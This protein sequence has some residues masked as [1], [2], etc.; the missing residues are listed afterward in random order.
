MISNS[1]T[2]HWMGNLSTSR[3]TLL[4]HLDIERRGV[5]IS[6]GSWRYHCPSCR[7]SNGSTL[8]RNTFQ[9]NDRRFERGEKAKQAPSAEF[10]SMKTTD[11]E[12]HVHLSPVSLKSESTVSIVIYAYH[13]PFPW[14]AYVTALYGSSLTPTKVEGYKC[15]L[16]IWLPQENGAGRRRRV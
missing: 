12:N 1:R 7:N 16:T 2:L 6:L 15:P 8:A 11:Q 14:C 10:M 5:D 13:L 3:P 9:V 4:A